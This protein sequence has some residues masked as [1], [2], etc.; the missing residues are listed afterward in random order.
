MRVTKMEKTSVATIQFTKADLKMIARMCESA[1]ENDFVEEKEA[2][3]A[4]LEEIWRIVSR[5]G[6]YEYN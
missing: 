4:I 2:E 5:L 3:F 6:E 1:L